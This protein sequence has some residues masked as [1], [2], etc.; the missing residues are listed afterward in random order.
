MAMRRS[1]QVDELKDGSVDGEKR[2]A[3]GPL[4]RNSKLIGA[5]L[6]IQNCLAVEVSS[7]KNPLQAAF[8]RKDNMV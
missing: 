4:K 6:S 3:A 7:L 1:G 5:C 2:K 8:H